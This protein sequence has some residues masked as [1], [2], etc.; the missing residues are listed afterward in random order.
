MAGNQLRLSVVLAALDNASG[1]FRRILAG[2]KGVAAGIRQTQTVLKNLNAQQKSMGAFR[3]LEESAGQAGVALADQRRKLAALTAQYNATEKPTAKLTRELRAQASEVG[4][5][6]RQHDLQRDKLSGQRQALAAAGIDTNRLAVH[7][8]QLSGEIDRTNQRMGQQTGQLK[9]M[10]DASE[11]AAKIHRAG[12]TASLHG[13]GML[14]AGQRMLRAEALPLGEAMKFESA[15]ADVRK[16]V[17]FPTPQGFKQM[18]QDVQDLSLHLPMIPQDIAAIV[19]AAG[20]AGIARGELLRFAEDATKMGVAFDT[21]ADDAG[22]T[23]ATWR[24][25][26]RMNQDAVVQLA[27]RINYLGNTG[28]ANVRQISEVVNRIG[29]L[30][31]VAGLQSGPLAALG[32]T[33]AGMGIQSE[34]SATGIKNMLLTLA[35]GSAATKAQ[36]GVFEAIGVDAEQMAKHLQDDAGGAIMSVLEKLRQ[37]PKETQAGMMTKLFGR[38]SIGAIAPLLTNLELLRTNFAKVSDAQQYQGSM[39][40]EYA[41]RVATS[42]NSLQLLKNSM[43]VVAQSIGDTLI[44]DFKAFAAHAGAVVGRVIEWTRANPELVRSI[45]R[46]TVGTTALV[47]VLGGL[48]MGAGFAAMAFSQIHNA[49]TILTGGNGVMSL[50]RSLGQLGG[51]VLPWLTKGARLLIPALTGISWPVVAIGAAVAAVAAVVW[52]YWGPIKAFM[53]GVWEGLRAAAAPVIAEMATALAPLKPAWDAVANALSSVW[54]WAKQLLTP[55]DATREQLQGATDAGRKFGAALVVPM[56]LMVGLFKHLAP[57]AAAA[58]KIIKVLFRY[59]PLGMIVSN[60]GPV[61]GFLQMLW[62]GISVAARAA[63][64]VLVTVFRYTPLGLIINNWAP[65]ARFLQALWRGVTIG[66]RAAWAVLAT[67]FRYSPLGLIINNWA[68]VARFLQALWRGVTVA[69]RSAWSALTTVFRYSPLGLIINNWAPVARF[70]QGLWSSVT[71]AASAAWA[72]V[73]A[74]LRLSPLG[75]LITNWTPIS[76][77]LRGLLGTA[78]GYVSAAWD[79]IRVLFSYSPLGVLIAQWTPIAGFFTG[80]WGRIQQTLA[81]AMALVLALIASSPARLTGGL[82]AMWSA[83]T[84]VL[85]GWPLK[86]TQAGADMVIGL[87]AGI[88]SKIGAAVEAI[89]GVGGGVIDRFKAM[90]GIHSPSRV[91]AQLGQFTMQGLAGGLLRAQALPMQ[92]MAGLGTR[93]QQAGAGVAMAAALATTVAIDKRPPV[94][95]FQSAAQPSGDTYNITIHAGSTAQGQDIAQQVR[96]ELERIEREKRARSRSRL[97]D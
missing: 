50:V 65:V 47:T 81:S 32:A 90:L 26:F 82:Q 23:M 78:L 66:A 89:G 17:D 68:P 70:L 7:Q 84:A 20:Q 67:V 34:V 2:S 91:F 14:Y 16:V 49:M 1:P 95:A 25:A 75:V 37:L 43:L 38:E 58:W 57:V 62:R 80:L 28:P 72:R 96:A 55:F 71:G 48:L 56:R 97:S 51:R 41:S 86:M 69:A 33:V 83:I 60:W 52:R 93:M 76:A 10:Q 45:T 12:M 44:P 9:R 94:A 46:I 53:I 30:G 73:G 42:E 54:N 29:A 24:T 31:E 3:A 13:A 79:R 18:G 61:G 88:R 77:F 74:V 8:R 85:A 11:R 64:S 22:Q 19:A 21:T 87:I 63:W 15:M 5:L 27:D 39:Q 6:A 35:A 4:K 92:A 59:S 40:A 36:R